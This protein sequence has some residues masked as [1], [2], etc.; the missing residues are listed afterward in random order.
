MSL[1]SGLWGSACTARGGAANLAAAQSG[2]EPFVLLAE[3]TRRD[4]T[5]DRLP[6]NNNMQDTNSQLDKETN[7]N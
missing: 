6:F 2:R 4:V 3:L 1:S 7:E 5:V